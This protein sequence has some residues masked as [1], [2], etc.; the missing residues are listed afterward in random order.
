M[1]QG[2]RP[3]QTNLFDSTLNDTLKHYT[4]VE[5]LGNNI[6]LATP[7]FLGRYLQDVRN[8]NTPLALG[9]A[10]QSVVAEAADS[11][12]PGNLPQSQRGLLSAVQ[13]ERMELG[14]DGPRY[15]YLLLDLRYLRRY[16][17]SNTAPNQVSAMPDYL[18]VSKT[19]FFEHLKEAR[20]ALGLALLKLVQP[21]LRLEQ[22]VP[23]GPIIGRKE[24]LQQCFSELRNGRSVT[25]TGFSGIGKTTFASAVAQEWARDNGDVYWFTFRP[26]LNDDL[27]SL[28]F[29]LA[30]FLSQR[31]C[32]NLWLQLNANQGQIDGIEQALGFLREDFECASDQNI[33][34]CFDEIDL[35]HTSTSQ[36]SKVTYGQLFEFIKSIEPIVPLLL[37]G[38]LTLID[39]DTYYNLPPLSPHQTA[40][41]VQR[42]HLSSSHLAEQLHQ[43]TEGNPRLI[44][45]LLAVYRDESEIALDKFSKSVA[46]ETVFQSLWNRLGPD[47]KA[48]M[49][50]LSAFR[51]FAPADEWLDELAFQHL[52]ERNLLKFDAQGGVALLPLYRNLVY[53]TLSD[54]RRQYSHQQAATI[55][56]Q[57]GRYTEAAYH[58][59]LADRHEL[60]VNLWY[61]HQDIEISQG[62]TSAAYSFFCQNETVEIGGKSAKKLALIQN[63]LNLLLGE[64]KQ[65]VDRMAEIQWEETEK[66]TADLYQQMGEAYFI[67]GDTEA[68]LGHYDDAIHVLSKLSNQQI[69]LHQKRG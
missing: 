53:E 38:Q 68:A 11:L 25:I 9:I 8:P 10:L 56:D 24:L 69:F 61:D 28:I 23:A 48:L 16:F 3:T 44:E 22:P 59:W 51:S 20:E 66:E 40:K 6:P 26:G 5:W 34:F 55:R 64:A 50:T 36:R 13:E 58:L 42:T 30:H 18:G 63:R 43:I 4:D 65:V 45:L 52:Q 54:H 17:P 47:E 49:A 62:Q 41:F 1:K 46:I 14:N 60:A 39:T 15:R 67:S 2:R 29:T 32:A 27:H 7:Y 19:R 21:G 12:W 57:H 31:G 33:L 35:L 37:I